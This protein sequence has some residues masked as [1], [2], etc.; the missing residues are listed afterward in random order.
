MSFIV[1]TGNILFIGHSWADSWQSELS[2]KI[3]TEYDSN[4]SLSPSYPGS[5]W[6]ALFE[7]N[8]TVMKKVGEYEFKGGIALQLA[9]SLNTSVS[10]DLNNPTAFLDWSRK[11]EMGE[12]GLS[13]KYSEIATREAGI[14]ATGLVPVNSTL[15]SRNLAARWSK[16]LDETN[17]LSSTGIY[18]KDTYKGGNFVDYSTWKIDLKL[19]HEL[20]E[21]ITA[22]GRISS[23]NYSPDNSGIIGTPP[24]VTL[25]SYKDITLGLIFK[26]SFFD[27]GMQASESRDG[28]GLTRRQ[29]TLSADYSGLFS[30]MS[31]DVER[32]LMPSGLGGYVVADQ[33][34]AKWSYALS[35]YSKA[36]VDWDW[37]KNLSLINLN[38]PTTTVISGAWI[39]HDLNQ[40]WKMRTYYTHRVNQG[41]EAAGASS[42]LLGLSFAYLHSSF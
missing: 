35:E 2:S 12:A 11:T 25:N 36:G 7:P 30:Q 39:E 14:D 15:T 16:D 29:G 24:V 6:R 5:A 33:A 32:L 34:N 26:G 18:E 20:S 9:R 1:M 13:S 19:S 40:E 21:K 8:F 23:N 4:P 17:K 42:N 10:Q 3:S 28:L 37:Q 27:W 41:G 31:F 22:F 38:S